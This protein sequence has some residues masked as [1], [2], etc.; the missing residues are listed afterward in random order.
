MRAYVLHLLRAQRR[1]DNAR[2]LLQNCGMAGEIWPA[3]D[4]AAMAPADLPAQYRRDLF[5]PVYPFELRIGE[6][7]CFLSHRQIWADMQDQPED[8]ALIIEDDAGIGSALLPTALDLAQRHV[9]TFGYIQLQTRPTPGVAQLIETKGTATLT[10]PLLPGL[11]TTAQVVSKRAAAQLL[12]QRET[13]D[14]PVDTWLQSH[15]HT[16][17]RVAA[18]HPSGI[19]EVA[20]QLDGSTIQTAHKSL[21]EKARREVLRGRYRRA[22]RRAAATSDAPQ[23][24]GQ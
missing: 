12:T 11:R 24:G 16:G 21:M 23:E 18:I 9:Q 1:T 15:W 22:A 14:R 7:G 10:L 17:L 8:T 2:A 6:I 3:V 20:D 5:H 4:G 19:L 13:F